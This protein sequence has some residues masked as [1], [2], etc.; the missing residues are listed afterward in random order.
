MSL[1]P[2]LKLLKHKIRLNKTKIKLFVMHR[3]VPLNL[4]S[5]HIII[6]STQFLFTVHNYTY[7]SAIANLHHKHTKN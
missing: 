1:L 3:I 7:R 6:I 2:S 4:H 5:F